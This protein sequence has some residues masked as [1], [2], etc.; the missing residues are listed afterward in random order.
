MN[1]FQIISEIEK[2]DPEVYDRLDSR[3]SIFKHMTGL[4]QKLSAA[5]LP[6]AV[7]AI[8]NK[9]YAQTPMNASVNDVLNFA[10]S[11]EYLESYFYNA[12]QASAPLQLGL[13]TTNKAA[14]EIIRVD[15]SNHVTFLRGVL[16]A[17]A[18]TPPTTA[19]F[20]YTGGKGTGAGP[21][22]DVFINPATY[23]AVAQSLEDT[24]VRAYKG[25]APLLMSNKTVLTAALNIHSVEARHASRLRTMRRGGANNNAA[26]QGV[27]AA[28]YNAAPKSW[29]SGTDNGGASP[30]Q[31]AP[32]YGA[33]NNTNAPT[34]VTFDAESNTTQGGANLTT[35]PNTTGFPASAFSEA[36]DEA[37]DV[38]TVKAI[39]RTFVVNGSTFLA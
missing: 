2:V 13:S 7:G 33:G 28:P 24:G 25:G 3:R 34:G 39:A 11:L 27:P 36:F 23:L 16:G 1:L 15:E 4:G 38:T 12:G 20:D 8:F 17:A 35:L 30:A 18:I 32:I 21:F 26:S 5:A 9:V 10:L 29:I 19:T 37:L 14:L 6:L 31:T 22:A